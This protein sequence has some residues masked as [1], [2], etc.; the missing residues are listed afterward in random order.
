MGWREDLRKSSLAFQKYVVPLIYNQNALQR[1]GEIKIC[2]NICAEGFIL[3]LDT[4]AG[5]DA[6]HVCEDGVWGI[7]V[8]ILFKDFYPNFTVRYTRPNNKTE[9]E[10]RIESMYNGSIYPYWTIQGYVINNE[11]IGVGII[12]TVDLYNF[13]YYNKMECREIPNKDNSSTFLAIPWKVLGN[14]VN[15]WSR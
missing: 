10:K 5:V 11:L 1:Y 9:Y 2:E 14:N 15:I 12:K 13:I 3:D 4:K 6:F 8:R 7:A